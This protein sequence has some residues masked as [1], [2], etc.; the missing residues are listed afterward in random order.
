MTVQ[1]YHGSPND[2]EEFSFDFVGT[3]SGTTGAGYGL[4]FSESE[5]EA[6]T[7]G[8]NIFKCLLTLMSPVSNDVV[9]ITPYKLSLILNEL[10]EFHDYNHY[11]NYGIQFMKNNPNHVEERFDKIYK[12]IIDSATCDT[13]I[14]GSII[15]SG[16]DVDKMMKALRANGFTHTVDHDESVLDTEGIKHYIVYDVNTIQILNKYTLETRK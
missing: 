1:V 12:Q 9:T 11:E 15:N 4:Y 10:Y 3:Q 6:L 8:E 7:Y 13:E 5:A 16:C 14:I 2:F